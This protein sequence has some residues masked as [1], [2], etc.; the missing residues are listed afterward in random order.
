MFVYLC[1]VFS[2]IP[3]CAQTIHAP[4]M[5]NDIIGICYYYV[6]YYYT[7]SAIPIWNPY[8]KTQTMLYRYNKFRSCTQIYTTKSNIEQDARKAM[9]VVFFCTY[10]MYL[11]V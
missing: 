2:L 3:L 11:Y 1:C 7:I 5:K 4:Q 6:Y 8:P 9:R 10:K